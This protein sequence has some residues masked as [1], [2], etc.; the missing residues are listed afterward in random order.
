VAPHS[1]KL[2]HEPGLAISGVLEQAFNRARTGLDC[3]GFQIIREMSLNEEQT[4]G[5]P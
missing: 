1:K 2:G 4:D 5:S 3:A